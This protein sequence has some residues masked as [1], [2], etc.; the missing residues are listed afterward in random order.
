MKVNLSLPVTKG[1]TRAEF[2]KLAENAACHTCWDT[3]RADLEAAKELNLPGLVRVLDDASAI[4]VKKH[5]ENLR[6]RLDALDL[7][8][9]NDL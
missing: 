2:A 3:L 8:D 4:K 6:A 1:L 5:A 9:V 7:G